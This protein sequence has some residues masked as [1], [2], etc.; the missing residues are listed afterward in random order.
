ML[1]LLQSYVRPR[2]LPVPYPV[3]PINR[4]DEAEDEELFLAVWMMYMRQSYGQTEI[5]A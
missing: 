1:F 5:I 4:R 3:P 2:P